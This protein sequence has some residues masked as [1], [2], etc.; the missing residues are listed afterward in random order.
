MRAPARH[1]LFCYG[2]LEFPPILEAVAG[3]RFPGR[4][5]VLP[6]YRRLAVRGQ[7]FPGIVAQAGAEV[8]GT[9]YRGLSNAHLRRLDAYE[10]AFYRR[11]RSLA[12]GV[13]LRRAGAVPAPPGSGG[14]G[15]GGFSA[16]PL[17][18][19]SASPAAVTAQ[20]MVPGR[21]LG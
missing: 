9:L 11:R 4:A 20:G 16:A 17:R 13:D 1:R 2:T 5:A 6:G 12:S 21:H 19:L 8:G 14:L 7:V 10:N 18:A 15:S 3:R